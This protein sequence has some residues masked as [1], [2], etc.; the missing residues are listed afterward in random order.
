MYLCADRQEV[1][2]ERAVALLVRGRREARG[3]GLV[4]QGQPHEL[5]HA[6]VLDEVDE[7][8][9]EPR[10]RAG[11]HVERPA[12]PRD[13]DGRPGA[14]R[15]LDG[16]LERLEAVGVLQVVVVDEDPRE[17][18]LQVDHLLLEVGEVLRRDADIA[19]ELRVDAVVELTAVAGE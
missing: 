16:P 3:I 11:L 1:R 12:L 14:L 10:D 17:L 4:L 6:A 8:V 7:R 19:A 13:V 18:R 5:R 15:E 2:V 9:G